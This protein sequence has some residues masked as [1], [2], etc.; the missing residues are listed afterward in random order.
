MPT[1][2]ASTAPPSPSGGRLPG[3]V[4]LLAL[5]AAAF[6]AGAIAA[7]LDDARAK[8][9]DALPAK[10]FFSPG[11]GIEPA[12]VDAIKGARA[13]VV[14]AMYNFT[15]RDLAE[16]LGRAKARG[17][18]VRVVLDNKEAFMKYGK[19]FD[20]RKSKIPVKLMALGKTSDDQQIRFHHKFM[21]I[22]REVVCTGS[23][24]WTQQA[25]ESNWENEVVLGSRKL[26]AEFLTQF[27]KAWE[28][29]E[30]DKGPPPRKS[31]APDGGPDAGGGK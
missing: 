11:G 27:E 21:V 8:G 25:D 4:G 1:P 28:A 13:E 12:L 15:S 24:N 9:D 19:L 20:L 16:A 10:A 31:V 30:E 14:I 22:D 2:D 6:L 7:P 23:F 29:A 26:A 18:D 17:V 5:A 3:R